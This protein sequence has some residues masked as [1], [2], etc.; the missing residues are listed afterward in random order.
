MPVFRQ[1]RPCSTALDGRRVV[2]RVRETVDPEHDEGY[3]L[4]RWRLATVGSDGVVKEV[5]L[6]PDTPSF[7]PIHLRCEDG[8]IRAL[9]QLL[10]VIG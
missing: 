1:R 7:P 3:T 10:E 8:E 4:K 6:Y 2:V 5:E 9:A